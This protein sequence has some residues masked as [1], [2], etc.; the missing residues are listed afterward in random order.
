MVLL[1]EEPGKK[2]TDF[3]GGRE[4]REEIYQ[5]A[6]REFSEESLYQFFHHK[7][8]VENRLKH[9]WAIQHPR[10]KYYMYP[11]QVHFVP[12]DVLRGKKSELI[13]KGLTLCGAEKT[14]FAWVIAG[15]LLAAIRSNQPEVYTIDGMKIKLYH[16]FFELLHT[17]YGQS[18]LTDIIQHKCP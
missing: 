1:G 18:I 10:F 5:T 4:E 13:K 7:S 2:W 17:A 8:D 3:G 14:N 12:A 6:A 15:D 16:N 9:K 11:L